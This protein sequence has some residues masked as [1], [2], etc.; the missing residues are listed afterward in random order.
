MIASQTRTAL[1]LCDTAALALIGWYLMVPPI[2]DGREVIAPVSEWAHLDSFDSA[3]ECRDGGY[4][5]QDR[6]KAEKKPHPGAWE[7]IA[8][9]DPRL[10]G[11]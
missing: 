8:S 11:K 2:R 5:Y 7:C 6:R 9:D 10:K 3:R 1:S 4:K